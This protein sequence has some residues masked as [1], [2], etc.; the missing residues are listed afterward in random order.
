MERTYTVADLQDIVARLRS[1]TGCPWDRVQTHES[2]ER[3]MIEEAYEVVEGIHILK[4]TGDGKNLCEELGDVL[5]QVIFHSQLAEEE[6]QF[7]LEQV[8]GGIC[9]KMIRR[10]PHVFAGEQAK[11]DSQI[12]ASWEEIK[13]QEKKGKKDQRSEL[14]SVPRA[15]PALLRAQKVQ[16][17]LVQ[18]GYI[19]QKSAEVMAQE[20]EKLLQC[21][22][23][24]EAME[25]QEATE[26]TGELL[27]EICRMAGRLGVQG[28]EALAAKVE[29]EVKRIKY[30]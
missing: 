16:K 20:C 22:A 14:E 10:H 19:P 12:P 4:E 26:L 27:Y 28:E 13:K 21:L 11:D 23:N 7:A 24:G 18:G 1:E 9:E 17:K 2:L 5:L 25:Q 6:G 30:L 8:V 15:F 3:C 29:K